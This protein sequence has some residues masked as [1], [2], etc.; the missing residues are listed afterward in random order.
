MEAE[1]GQSIFRFQPYISAVYMLFQGESQHTRTPSGSRSEAYPI[2]IS[3]LF[4]IL[5]IDSS[6]PLR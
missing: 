3:S 1:P 5:R 2:P 6:A 4:Y